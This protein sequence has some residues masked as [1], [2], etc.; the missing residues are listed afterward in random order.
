MMVSKAK[1]LI[2]GEIRLFTDTGVSG[3]L[4]SDNCARLFASEC[5]AGFVSA[6]NIDDRDRD[7][8]VVVSPEVNSS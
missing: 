6:G 7:S 4:D 1:C 5:I 8:P 3:A 2:A